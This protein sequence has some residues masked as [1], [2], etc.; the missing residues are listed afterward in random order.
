[1]G[2]MGRVMGH[3]RLFPS[4]FGRAAMMRAVG[5]AAMT[6]ALGGCG[7]FK[8]DATPPPCPDV[9]VLADASKFTRFRPGDGRDIT[10]IVLQGEV[11]GF[12]GACKYSKSDK[13]MTVT[14]QVQLTFTRGPAASAPDAVVSYF[15]AV[16]SFIPKP[17]AKKVMDLKF[18]FAGSAEHVRIT[19]SEINVVL[20]MADLAKDVPKD[21]IFVGFQLSPEELEYNRR[22]KAQ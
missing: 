16:P 19:D 13:K 4:L 21:E 9:T 10:D 5:V 7:L 8:G 2:L 6:M 20:P 12:K 15:I 14:I 11:T 18:A 22:T 17:E 3:F 1:M